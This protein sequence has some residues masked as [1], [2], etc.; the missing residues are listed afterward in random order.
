MKKNNHKLTK[1]EKNCKT[2]E[3]NIGLTHH[4]SENQFN[5]QVH[6]KYCIISHCKDV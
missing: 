2:C 4:V 5:Y 3:K 1:M 6:A